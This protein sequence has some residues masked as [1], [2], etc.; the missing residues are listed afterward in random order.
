VLDGRALLSMYV[1]PMRTE[2]DAR[3][4]HNPQ[5]LTP[6]HAEKIG[7]IDCEEVLYRQTEEMPWHHK[8]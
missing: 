1:L 5:T 8:Y 6:P 3:Y 4:F 7:G 2:L